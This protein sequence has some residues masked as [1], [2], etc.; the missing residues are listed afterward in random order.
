M[1]I[2]REKVKQQTIEACHRVGPAKV[3][4]M[5]ESTFGVSSLVQ[6]NDGDLLAF[7]LKLKKL[8]A[9]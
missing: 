9:D 4:A 1:S 7:S 5:M 6:L 8:R 3:R 2:D